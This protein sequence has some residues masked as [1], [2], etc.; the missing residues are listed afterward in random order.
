MM[1]VCVLLITWQSI[2]DICS[3]VCCKN[4]ISAFFEIIFTKT[5]NFFA[6]KNL[7]TFLFP[8]GLLPGIE[9]F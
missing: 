8:G 4:N 6:I 1:N 7:K 9:K 3:C 5:C 2:S